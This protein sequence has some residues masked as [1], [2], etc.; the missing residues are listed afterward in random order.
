MHAE[1]ITVVYAWPIIILI[2]FRI[3]IQKHRRP[4]TDKAKILA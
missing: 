1:L 2:S 3:Y 4:N